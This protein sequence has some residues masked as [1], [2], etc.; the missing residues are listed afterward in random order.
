MSLIVKPDPDGE[1]EVEIDFKPDEWF[2]ELG[3]IKAMPNYMWTTRDWTA[4]LL[5][6][7][8]TIWERTKETLNRNPGQTGTAIFVSHANYIKLYREVVNG[9]RDPDEVHNT[10]VAKDW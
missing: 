5:G 3:L 7:D 2:K 1:R 9:H 8:G 10:P 6:R 4:V